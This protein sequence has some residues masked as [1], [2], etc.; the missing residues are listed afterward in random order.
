MVLQVAVA[1]TRIAGQPVA[2]LV[3]EL[4]RQLEVVGTAGLAVQLDQRGLD[5]RVAVEA[6]LLAGELAH[7][8]IGELDSDRKQAVIARAAMQRDRGLDEVAGAV[9]LV[10]PGEPGIPWLAAGLEVGV[11]VAI[12]LLGR[13]KRG[14]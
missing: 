2:A 13:L 7:Q 11:E 10:A 4:A 6:P 9:H 8:V 5:H 1:Q 3:D 12:G 14:R